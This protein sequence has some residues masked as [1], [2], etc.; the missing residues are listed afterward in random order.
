MKLTEIAVDRPITTIM[1]VMIVIAVSVVALAKLPIDLMPDVS[2]PALSVAINYPG[3]SPEEIENLVTRPI[4][5]AMS[6]V[7]GVDQMESTS[8]EEA[9]LIRLRFTWGSDLETVANDVRTRLDRI[10]GRLPEDIEPPTLY[11]FDFDQRPIMGFGISSKSMTSL[12]LR[13]LAENTLKNRLERVPGVASVDVAGGLVREIQV[14]LLQEKL[15]ALDISPLTI[16]EA[17]RSENI[18]LPAG[19]VNEGE[20]KLVMRTQGQFESPDELAHIVVAT[21][22]GVPIYLRDVADVVDGHEEIR[23]IERIN[24]RPGVTMSLMKQSGS[25]SVTVEDAVM[26]EI[27]LIRRDLPQVDLA[28]LWQ[29]ATYIK[30][31][32]ANVRTAAIFGAGLAVIILL[33]FLRNIRS[34]LIIASAVPISVMATFSLIYFAGFSLN[35]VS[36]GGLAL[37]IGLLLDNSIVVLENIFRHREAGK[38]GREAAIT[39]TREVSLAITASTFTTLVVFLP[40]VFISG[41]ASVMFGQLGFVVAF[42]LACSL[43]VALTLIPTLSRRLLHIEPLDQTENET[44]AH[45]VYRLSE[46]GLNRVED[47]YKRILHFALRHRGAVILGS[48]TVFAATMPL[49]RIQGFEYMPQADEGEVRVYGQMAPGTKMEHLDEAFRQVEEIITET[50][51]DDVLT[52]HTRFGMGQWYRSSGSNTGSVRL[53]LVDF[54]DRTRSSEEIANRLRDELEGIPGMRVRTRASGGLFIYRFLQ[55]QGESVAVEIRGHDRDIALQLAHA[56]Q[57]SLERVEGI[58]DTR[59]SREGGRPEIGLQID[60]QK[61]AEAGLSVTAIAQTIRTNF[62]GEIATQYRE[63]GNEFNVRVRLREE[64]RERLQDLRSLWIVTPSGERVPVSNFIKERRQIGPTQIRRKNQER[65]ITVAANLDEGYSLGNVMADIQKE[66]APL[67]KSKPKDFSLIY[68]GEYED[69]QKSYQ[70]LAVGLTLA[71]LLIYMV[72]AAQF[73][74][75]LHPLI[76]MFAIP[77]GG[78][79]VLLSLIITDT[80]VNI[81]SILGIIMLAG[82]V[83]NNA[84]VLVDYINLLRR[85]QNMGLEEAVEEAGRRRL[86]PILMTTLTTTLALVPMAIGFGAGGEIQA[87]MARVV[88]GGLLTSTL[89]TLVFVPTLYTTVEEA[90]EKFRARRSVLAVEEATLHSVK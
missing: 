68:G 5:E 40:L 64:D 72:M 1:A 24:G 65:T 61:A 12:E 10:R 75:F 52:M 82:I 76:I 89:I 6:S 79:G 45:K 20:I 90:L 23:T 29:S 48:I 38:D 69:Q 19:E 22:E 78:I 80:T 15:D 44:L 58:T 83:V 54:K 51:G 33:L 32:I 31:A 14:N 42:S 27:D 73:E 26:K 13:H 56:V 47:Q 34:T 70:E 86:R 28:I 71:I 21:R 53:G 8:S 3:A 25:N 88:I 46:K 60:R 39:G 87:P 43:I 77:F 16:L 63:G 74:S 66:L 37:G 2:Y 36:F 67:E 18:N 4:E 81:Q 85:E 17:I 49:F 57:D 62:G 7:A 11:K 50:V 84:I 55:N 30:E 41:A 59:L 35:V 9:S